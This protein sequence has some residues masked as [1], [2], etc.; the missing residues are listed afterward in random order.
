ME[1][2]FKDNVALCNEVNEKVVQHIVHCISA[3]GYHV[4]YLRL[5]QTLVRAENQYVR[6]CQ[7]L[8]MAELINLGEEVLVFYNEKQAFQNFVEMMRTAHK[9][10]NSETSPL[11]YH[12]NLVRLLSYCT[13]GKNVY[14]EIKCH[15]LL[16]LD[17]IVRV[18]T[19]PDCTV[20]VKQVYLT[21]LVH[22]YIDTEVEMKDIYGSQH[23]WSLFDNFITDITTVSPFFLLVN[24]TSIFLFNKRWNFKFRK[25]VTFKISIIQNFRISLLQNYKISG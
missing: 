8:V 12:I 6:R 19:H 23:I 10:E 18:V 21:F 20:D 11:L 1:A 16:P 15:S 9:H 5:L 7:D 25:I 24:F 3:H 22:C 14:T 17:D 4:Q 13:E 2:I